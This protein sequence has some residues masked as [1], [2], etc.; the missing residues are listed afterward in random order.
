MTVT[1]EDSVY[2]VMG[3][4]IVVTVESVKKSLSTP[5]PAI[6]PFDAAQAKQNQR[7]WAAHLCVP[8]EYENSLRMKFV[9]IPPGEFT[10]GS[11]PA[12]IEKSL[13]D[14]GD[15]RSLQ[16]SARSEGPQHKVILTQPMYLGVHEVTQ[17]NYE[18]V[19]GNNPA[20]FAK[21]GRE[22]DNAAKVFGMDTT[23]HPV[24]GLRWEEA[25]DFCNKLSELEKLTPFQPPAGDPATKAAGTGYRLPTEALWEFACRAGTTTKYSFG[26]KDE[27]LPQAAW[28]RGNSDWRPHKVGELKANPLGLYDMHGNVWEWMQDAFEPAYYG[29]FSEKPAQDPSGP[30]S[31][32]TGRLLRGGA[33]NLI[34]PLCGSSRRFASGTNVNYY[35]YGFRVALPVDA[36]KAAIAERKAQPVGR[37]REATKDDKPK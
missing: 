16:D 13:K 25:V 37:D 33:W 2:F 8:V 36:V 9:L 12:E 21:A 7:A 24:E 27:D 20:Y 31:T 18:Q 30:T 14:A 29:Q 3:M 5:K 32:G 28:F 23:V 10:M 17:G 6:A 34:A 35:D 19:M 11:T 4:R 26:D 15:N 22:R 1:T